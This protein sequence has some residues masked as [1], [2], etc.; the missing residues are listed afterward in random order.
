MDER[1]GEKRRAIEAFFVEENRLTDSAR[2]SD[3]PSGRFRLEICRYSTGPKSWNYSRGIVTRLADGT[4]LA[5]VKRN[6]GHFWHSWMEHANGHE[7]L[8]CGEDYQGYSV[9][10]LTAGTCKTFFPQE[11]YGGGGFC[12]A[13]VYASPDTL[14][15]AVDGCYWAC[16]YDVV[17]Y[18]FRDPEHLPFRELARVSD[19]AD[20]CEGWMDNESFVLKREVELRRS[21]GVPYESLEE[22]EQAVLDADPG[23][24]EYRT[25]TVRLMRPAS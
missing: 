5:D 12:W 13:E 22:D 24:V 3:S 14:V 16:P 15:L 20:R 11:G 1:Y 17:L 2:T 25:E 18:D 9:V 6:F 23:L 7:Y 10:N 21:D 8:L 19:V 4:R